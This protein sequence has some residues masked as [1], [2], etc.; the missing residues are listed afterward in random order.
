M[1]GGQMAPT[2]LEGQK[3]TTTPYGRDVKVSGYP[4]RVSELLAT[5]EG[6]AYIE[7]VSLIDPANV[8]KAKRAVKKAFENQ[9]KGFGFSLIEVLSPCPVNWG[10]IPVKA[11]EFIK[12]NMMEY[13]KIGVIK[14]KTK[15]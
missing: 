9:V 11:L 8:M 6:A 10:L 14:D 13:Y 4:L 15:E 2:T 5:I 3:T 1:T 12:N 7:R